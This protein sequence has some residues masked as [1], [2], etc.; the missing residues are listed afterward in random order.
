MA[1]FSLNVT[2]NL[3]GIEGGLLVTNNKEYRD[4]ANMLRMFGEE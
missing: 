4:G 3:P 2:K 1:A